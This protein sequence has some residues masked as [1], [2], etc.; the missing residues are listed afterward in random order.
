[1][2]DGPDTR[3][4]ERRPARIRQAGQGHRIDRS[5]DRHQ[6]AGGATRQRDERRSA[7][8]ALSAMLAVSQNGSLPNKLIAMSEEYMEALRANPRFRVLPPSGKRAFDVLP[9]D[10]TLAT[11]VAGVGHVAERLAKATGLPRY[12]P[13]ACA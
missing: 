11:N 12:E 9:P 8:E 1:M 4:A 5:L 7:N 2:T 6:D 10:A 13:P 3:Q